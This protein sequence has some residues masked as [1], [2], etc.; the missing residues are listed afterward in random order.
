MPQCAYTGA[1]PRII[2]PGIA[3]AEP[4]VTNPGEGK[5]LNEEQDKD[6]PLREDIRLLGRLLG[7]T[8]REQEGTEAFEIVERIRR[9][10]IAFHRDNDAA[11]RDELE[12]TLDRLTTDETMIVVR[13]YS[14]FSH[15]ANIAED[16]HHI[17][18]SR[19]RWKVRASVPGR[20]AEPAM[21]W[22]RVR[23]MWCRSSAMLARCEK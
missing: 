1:V 9:S 7:D 17:R 21:A 12:G 14:Y 15:L 5:R 18:R 22:A 20:G 4:D 8:L 23:R 6:L 11:A 19:A 13:A 2:P 16:L 3:P 10:S